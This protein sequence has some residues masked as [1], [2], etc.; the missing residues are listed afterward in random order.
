ML[1]PRRAIAVT[2][3]I[4]VCTITLILILACVI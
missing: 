3:V 2:A 4:Y 1:S